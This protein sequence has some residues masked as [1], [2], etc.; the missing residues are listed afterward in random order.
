MLNNRNLER[1]PPKKPNPPKAEYDEVMTIILPEPTEES[2]QGNPLET[3]DEE[4][5]STTDV[6]L[7]PEFWGNK[8]GVEIKRALLDYLFHVSPASDGG[9]GR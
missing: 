7:L 1:D 5:L 8:Y 4:G 6:K 2:P 9:S 3:P